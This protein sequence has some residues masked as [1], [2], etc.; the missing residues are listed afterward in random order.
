MKLSDIQCKNAKYD[1]N[2]KPDGKYHKRFDGGGLYIHIK[3]KGKYWRF[4]YRFNNK[5]VILGFGVYP[6]VSL[7]EARNHRDDA[8]KLLSNGQ[9]PR[10]IKQEAKK[11]VVAKT[12]N[13]F[14]A[15]AK[16]WHEHNINR[17]TPENG[18]RIWRRLEA[19]IFPALGKK[20]I[21][22][23]MPS[24]IVTA[25]KAMEERGATY[26][27]KKTVQTCSAVF[28]YAKALDKAVFNPAADLQDVLK[29]HKVT[30]H[31]SIEAKELPTFYRKLEEVPASPTNKL[32]VKL[33]L[34]T[35]LRQGELRKC[36]W[37]YLDLEKKELIVPAEIMKMRKPHLVPLSSQ[38]MEVLK[39]IQAINGWSPYIFPSQQR[40]VHPY[41]S[42]NTINNIIHRMGYKGQ[43][44]AHGARSLASTVLN[45]HQFN[46]DV[47]ELQ[48]A[49]K[50]KNQI[51]GIYNRAEHIPE[52]HEMMKWWGGY[53]ERAES[54]SDNVLKGKF[55]E[56]GI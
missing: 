46:E 54:G 4:K 13:T 8:R 25:I 41:I 43:M 40:R 49:H 5:D 32:A 28:R 21:N 9:D 33:L 6:E 15:V 11:A 55:G 27:S 10:A 56:V 50:D 39:E 2:E 7:K 45:E 34:L 22:E 26:L 1:P 35:F 53:L 24:E 14:E 51:R 42:E 52:R 20:P 47:I 18:Q 44:V 12:E 3:P 16:E 38:A 23:I 36:M 48:L 30:H 19:N 29:Q 37:E 17:W 31:P